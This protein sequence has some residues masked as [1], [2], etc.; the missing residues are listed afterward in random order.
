MKV[1][2]Q[3]VIQ[4]HEVWM[5]A[6]NTV[7]VEF[8]MIIQAKLGEKEMF[9]VPFITNVLLRC[10]GGHEFECIVVDN[11]IV[12]VRGANKCL[13]TFF[14]QVTRTQVSNKPD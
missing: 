10:C 12:F 7:F 9:S 8:V 3:V 13:S 11:K 5:V 4:R 14:N 2:V 6:Y 1:L